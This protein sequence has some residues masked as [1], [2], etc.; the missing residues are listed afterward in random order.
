MSLLTKLS[1][2]ISLAMILGGGYLYFV[3]MPATEQMELENLS[4]STREKLTI[5]SEFMLP[6]LL[7]GQVAEIHENLDAILEQNKDWIQIALTNSTGEQIYPIGL[8]FKA[9]SSSYRSFSYRINFRDQIIGELWL[10]VDFEERLN[11]WR[12]Q[13]NQVLLILGI[14]FVPLIL[15]I[16]TFVDLNV[17]RPIEKLS[18]AAKKFSVGNYN[19]DLPDFR[20]DAV[21]TLSKTFSI[22]R[23]SIIQNE[24]RLRQSEERLRA[25]AEATPVPII[26]KRLCDDF[27]LYANPQAKLFFTGFKGDLVG[28]NFREYLP[29][30]SEDS[31]PQ[32]EKKENTEAETL[33]LRVIN[34]YG[35]PRWVEANNGVIEYDN[36]PAELVCLVDITERKEADTMKGE[37]VST[38]S[39]ELR[40]PLTSIMGSLG[41]ISGMY[42]QELSSDVS[43]LISV[44]ERNVNH[45]VLLINDL[46]DIQKIEAGKLDF[47]RKPFPVSDLLAISLSSMKGLSKQYGVTLQAESG[48]QDVMVDGDIHR[49]NQVL[50]NLVSNAMKF[51]E[52]GQKVRVVISN[53]KDHV[54]RISVVDQ[55]LGIP[56]EFHD[57]IFQKFAQADSTDSRK[58]PGTG[59]GLNISKL[60]VE[61]HDGTIGFT[62]EPGLGS[63]FF[64]DLPLAVPKAGETD[65]AQVMTV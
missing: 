53:K 40:T 35:T 44:S 33:E 34:A 32:N 49:L 52:L 29:E 60:I 36:E 17:R 39:H 14:G 16:G 37:F 12:K 7:S 56:L 58:K 45:L 2:T 54:I 46:L 18:Q 24:E 13:N 10:W 55:G 48:F 30:Y 20:D 4:S 63:T 57:R 21:G 25:I 23:E 6:L 59:L 3:W 27:I 19:A 15:I 64:F 50:L 43:D 22:M 31:F 62:S 26:V 11:A 8:D 28:R 61:A 51:S 38:V 47:E 9:M 5:T 1:L 41:L 42:G 65:I